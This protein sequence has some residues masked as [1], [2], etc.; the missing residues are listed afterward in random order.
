MSYQFIQL[1]LQSHIRDTKG[2]QVAQNALDFLDIET[3]TVKSS[4]VFAVDYPLTA[5]E[6]EDFAQKCLTDE[7]MNDTYIQELWD[8]AGFQSFIAV[9]KLPGVTDDEGTSAQKA[10]VDF[11][12]LSLDTNTQHIYSQ[13]IYYLQNALTAEELQT[14][15]AD[16]LGNKLIH[17]F[18]YGS[19]QTGQNFPQPSNLYVPKVQIAIDATTNTIDLDLSDS[20]LLDL[21]K[22]MVLALNLEEM[23]AIQN[24]YDAPETQAIRQAAGLPLKP[25]DCELEVLAQTWSEHCKHKEFNAVIEYTNHETGEH[26]TIKS[27]FKTFIK[28]ATDKVAASLAANNNNWLV[29]VFTDNAGVVKVNENTHFVFKVETHNSPSALDP[30]GGAI[31]GIL[32][33][34]RDPLGTGVGGAKLLFNTNVLCFGSPDFDGQLLTGQLHPK[35]IFAGVRSGI[36]DG[37]NKSGV[38]TVNGSIVFDDRYRGKPLVYCGT[39]AL[40]PPQYKGKNSWEKPIDANDRILVIGGRVGK[41]G[42]HGATFSSVEID[43][44]SPMSA[45]QIGSPIT[46]KLASDFLDKSLSSG[47]SE[48]LY[49]QWRRWFVLLNWRNGRPLWRCSG[50]IGES[51]FEIFGFETVGDIC[52]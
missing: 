46:Q 15:A 30:Y 7:I 41:D 37:G 19:L 48:M 5:S 10:L 28:G 38:P 29:K 32:G 42:I 20:E 1:S 44:H 16:L 21:S 40:M 49:G 18:Q 36:E 3:G 52:L 11:Q 26:K 14:I 9:A 2:E 34:N 39:G 47:L 35:R 31:T 4:R 23:K 17:H 33:N 8:G 45:V 22:R 24:H 51:T 13:D 43:E 6:L 12:N 50:R 27:L 25:T